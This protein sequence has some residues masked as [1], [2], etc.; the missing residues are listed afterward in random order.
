MRILKG[1]FRLLGVLVLLGTFSLAAQSAQTVYFRGVMSPANE[2]PPVTDFAAT[3]TGLIAVHLVRDANGAIQSA[4]VDFTVNYNFPA[5]AT[6]TGLHIHSGPAGVAAPV[7]INTGIGGGTAS[8]AAPQGTGTITR[9]AQVKPTD[10]TGLAT[11]NGMMQ[12]PSQYY[13]NIHTTAYPGGL[14]RA[15]LQKCVVAYFSG[16]MSAANEVPPVNST[17]NGTA[18]VVAIG[19]LDANGNITSG[20]VTLGIAYNFPSA[21]TFTGFHIHAGNSTVAGPVTINSTVANVASDPSGTGTLVRTVDVA[22][23]TTGATTLAGMFQTPS[24]Y[25]INIHTTEFPGGVIRAP[26]R[27]MNVVNFQVNMLPSNETP[28]IS[29]LAANGQASVSIA[30]INGNDGSVIGGF[31]IFDV[32]YRFPTSVTFTGLHIHDG[33]AGIAGPV[34]IN[35]GVASLA[36]T[37]DGFGNAFFIVPPQTSA[38]AVATLN[39]VI[40]SPENQYVNMH[41]TDNPGGAIRAQLSAAVTTPGTIGGTVSA[42]LDPSVTTLAPLGLASSFGTN[43]AKLTADG[44]GGNGLPDSL[45]GATVE[46]G[47]R[48]GRLL[49]VSPGQINFQVP[50]NVA[51][52]SQTLV[53][54]NGNA[55]SAPQTITV[56]AA[57]PGI[58]FSAAGGAVLKSDYSAVSATNPAAAGDVLLIYSTGLGQT[59]PP[60]SAGDLTPTGITLYRTVPVTVTVGG[61]NAAVLY[62]VAAP[63]F[64]GL[65]QTAVTM[66][67]GIAAGT[68]KVVLS[69]GAVNSNAV[70][71]A[72]K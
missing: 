57:A 29:G 25:Y 21:Q 61:Q 53:V 10:T 2:T 17:A 33:A 27:K 36:S 59:T 3:G 54:N 1:N 63:G 9:Q 28:P 16:I 32:N 26:L 4:S 37:A 6:V 71:I 66:P 34:R 41:T 49:Y 48:I 39:S 56:A 18:Q 62:S 23:G 70:N 12:D 50:G 45:A 14:M 64:A 22:P 47:G 15:Q 65:Y 8:V 72:T 69:V 68:A 35:T 19:A 24:N 5:D 40:N 52:G 46:V 31:A 43:L 58:F 44:G 11:L 38:A 13:V 30:T 55:D 42:V 20:T 67:A 60:L 51:T 7:T